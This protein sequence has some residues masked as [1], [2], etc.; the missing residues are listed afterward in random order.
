MKKYEIFIGLKNLV[1]MI[2]GVLLLDT[3]NAP[4]VAIILW[5]FYMLFKVII[6]YKK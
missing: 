1:L 5:L 2:F 6:D 3:Y 4:Y